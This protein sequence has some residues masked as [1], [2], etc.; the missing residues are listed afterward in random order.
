MCKVEYLNICLRIIWI[1]FSVNYLLMIFAHFM[2]DLINLQVLFI[3]WGYLP[4][5][6]NTCCKYQDILHYYQAIFINCFFPSCIYSI[7]LNQT[8]NPFHE[9][10]G[11]FFWISPG[12]CFLDL[13][14]SYSSKFKRE[15]TSLL[16]VGQMWTLIIIGVPI[17]LCLSWSD[18]TWFRQVH[19][20]V[21]KQCSL[22][23]REG[24]GARQ[25]YFLLSEQKT[26][27]LLAAIFSIKRTRK[28]SCATKKEMK[29]I[30][31]EE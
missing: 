27:D 21:I 9:K 12:K 1:P 23:N 22:W 10:K 5:V 19:Q 24:R 15:E 2:A 18:F 25:I 4:F 17:W 3:Y 13:P 11:H 20:T 16:G 31:S 29:Q 30:H 7:V 8:V 14:T 6:C 28:W 26:Q